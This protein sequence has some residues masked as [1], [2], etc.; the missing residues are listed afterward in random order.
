[1]QEV[2]WPHARLFIVWWV[3]CFPMHGSSERRA[4]DLLPEAFYPEASQPILGYYLWECNEFSGDTSRLARFRSFLWKRYLHSLA[5]CCRESHKVWICRFAGLL[6]FELELDDCSWHIPCH[7][8]MYRWFLEVV[9]FSMVFPKSSAIIFISSSLLAF[10]IIVA[11]KF[12]SSRSDNVSGFR[13]CFLLYST[14]IEYSVW[15]L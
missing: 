13:G 4:S 12:D 9:I 10:Q 2:Y 14:S 1:M 11:R 3:C 7:I 8:R 6:R 15:Q 5:S